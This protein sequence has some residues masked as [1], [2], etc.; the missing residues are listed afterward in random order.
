MEEGRSLQ[1]VLQERGLPS[2]SKPYQDSRS[3]KDAER[4]HGWR[5]D[6][7]SSAKA[8]PEDDSGRVI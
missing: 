7:A 8:L 3:Q 4:R 5:K 6:V 1:D 2:A